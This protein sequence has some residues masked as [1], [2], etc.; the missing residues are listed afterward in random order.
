MTYYLMAQVAIRDYERYAQYGAGFMPALNAYGGQVLAVSDAPEVLEGS[1][2][3]QRMVM[4]AFE[5]RE[6]AM[7][8]WNSPEYRA[9]V[10]HRH[11]ASEAVIVGTEGLASAP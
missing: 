4:V 11:A 2:S 6:A 7:A 1:W 3:G 10:G 5:T 8:W 9:I